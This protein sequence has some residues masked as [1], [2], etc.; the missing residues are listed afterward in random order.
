MI[1]TLIERQKHFVS[2]VRKYGL[3]Y[4]I[5]PSLPFLTLTA[6]LYDA[7]YSSLL[8]ELD[9]VFDTPLTDLEEA[10]NLPLTSLPFFSIIL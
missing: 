10:I 4:K 7:F 8:V 1:G 6:G 9:F 5:D 3:L 2:E